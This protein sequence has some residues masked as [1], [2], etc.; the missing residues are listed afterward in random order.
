MTINIKEK[1]GLYNLKIKG[2]TPEHIGFLMDILNIPTDKLLKFINKNEPL[3][4]KKWLEAP[5][6]I[7][8]NLN[9]ALA[10]SIAQ[11]PWEGLGNE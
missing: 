5:D 1:E 8:M 4:K 9:L 2:L 10:D 11:L 3:Y 7:D 6:N